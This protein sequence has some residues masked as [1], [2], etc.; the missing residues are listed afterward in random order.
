[1]LHKAAPLIRVKPKDLT[2]ARVERLPRVV[3][4]VSGQPVLFFVGLH[5]QY[6]FSSDMIH[7]VGRDAGVEAN[8]ARASPV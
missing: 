3:G 1:M 2:A 4:V 5:F 7:G 8:R 6:A